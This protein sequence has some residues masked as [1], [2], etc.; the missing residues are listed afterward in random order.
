MQMMS[1]ELKPEQKSAIAEMKLEIMR[2]NHKQTAANNTETEGDAKSNEDT[3]DKAEV[4]AMKEENMSPQ[5]GEKADKGAVDTKQQK[6]SQGNPDAKRRSSTSEGDE[7]EAKSAEPA[8]KKQKT[9]AS[10]GV[11]DDATMDCVEPGSNAVADPAQTG[12]PAFSA[13]EA[14]PEA[15]ATVAE[16]AAESGSANASA[17]KTEQ[18]NPEATT[19][20]QQTKQT[21]SDAAAPTSGGSEAKPEMKGSA[22]SAPPGVLQVLATRTSQDEEFRRQFIESVDQNERRFARLMAFQ[23]PVALALMDREPLVCGR[24]KLHE[25]GHFL[26]I[27]DITPH[28]RAVSRRHFSIH[29][30]KA[31]GTFYLKVLSQNGLMLNTQLLLNGMHPL[32][33]GSRIVVQ[34][35]VMFFEVPEN[36]TPPTTD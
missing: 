27:G 25:G 21:T 26:A 7:E 30:N 20:E 6:R 5:R 31:T 17:T 19:S 24:E 28:K 10:P 29:Y 32:K 4:A 1:V 18:T 15:A 11:D 9:S 23:P 13:K 12:A 3:T 2:R 36:F 33:N 16:A 35:F 34:H 22:V 8:F 14:A